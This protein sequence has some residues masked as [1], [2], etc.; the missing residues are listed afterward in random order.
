MPIAGMTP[1]AWERLRARGRTRY[2][3]L[4]GVLG[5]GLP[6]ALLVMMLFLVLEGRR[7]DSTLLGDAS[8]WLRLL[9]GAALFSVGGAASAYARW[10]SMELYFDSKREP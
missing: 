10:R 1:E 6:M 8:L 4:W 7:F 5:R 3:L 9:L 2:L